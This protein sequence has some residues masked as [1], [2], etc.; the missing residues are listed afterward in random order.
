M[1]EQLTR[2]QYV[3]REKAYM[4]SKARLQCTLVTKKGYNKGMQL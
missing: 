1:I 4:Y 3:Y 2:E